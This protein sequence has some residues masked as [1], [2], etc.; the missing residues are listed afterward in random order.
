M[1]SYAS[2]ILAT[3]IFQRIEAKI[4]QILSENQFVFKTNVETT[5]EILALQKIVQK[6]IRKEKL[7]YIALVNIKKNLIM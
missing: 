7:T 4:E 5:V 1:L 2:K 3:I 6:K